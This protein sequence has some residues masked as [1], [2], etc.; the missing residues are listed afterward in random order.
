MDRIEKEEKLIGEVLVE[1]GAMTTEQVDD[2]LRRQRDGNDSCQFLATHS[3][4][5]A[6]S[7][8][9]VFISA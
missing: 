2:I 5:R 9:I 8:P 1:M 4:T 7:T 6:W 3:P